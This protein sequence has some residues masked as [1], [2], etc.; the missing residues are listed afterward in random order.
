[1]DSG[2]Q[3]TGSETHT[4]M[5]SSSEAISRL[6]ALIQRELSERKGVDSMIFQNHLYGCFI[7]MED[8]AQ[9]VLE[10][11]N[12]SL[13][14]NSLY[15][16]LERQFGQIGIRYYGFIMDGKAVWEDV[17]L[18]YKEAWMEIFLACKGST[19]VDPIQEEVIQIIEGM[20]DSFFMNAMEHDGNLTPDWIEKAVYALH[21]HLRGSVEAVSKK[22][23][24]RLAMTRRQPRVSVRTRWATTR[25][26]GGSKK[27]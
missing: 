8:L 16:S 6:V 27:V 2:T 4:A 15:L 19:I 22:K 23:G 25:R 18:E 9:G 26:Q 24:H 17:P 21:P 5:T 7:V 1:M 20:G 12:G 14:G 3:G 13:T 10:L 11:A